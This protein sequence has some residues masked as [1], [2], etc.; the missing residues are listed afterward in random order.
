MQTFQED[1]GVI[2][3]PMRIEHGLDR[4]KVPAMEMMID[5]HAANI[6]ELDAVFAGCGK[7]RQCRRK[8]GV[9]DRPA[10]DIHRIGVQTAAL[11]GFCQGDG[12][13]HPN[14]DIVVCRRAQHFALADIF[15]GASVSRDKVRSA[16]QHQQDDGELSDV[17]PRVASDRLYRRVSRH[18]EHAPDLA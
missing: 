10:G 13:E 4:I 9:E 2:D 6:D 11:A 12:V 16:G 14:R 5:L 7:D 3:I 8:I 18:D 15:R 1:S 17:V